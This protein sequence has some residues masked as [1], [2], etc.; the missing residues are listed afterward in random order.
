MNNSTLPV[1]LLVHLLNASYADQMVLFNKDFRDWSHLPIFPV[2]NWPDLREK[3][4]LHKDLSPAL[5]NFL[6]HRGLLQ[7]QDMQQFGVPIMPAPKNF[8]DLRQNF[9]SMP[10][11]LLQAQV[12]QRYP[13]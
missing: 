6:Y 2:Q 7:M 5:G 10:M 12:V 8:V 13:T 9:L 1:D 4:S 11:N 3:L